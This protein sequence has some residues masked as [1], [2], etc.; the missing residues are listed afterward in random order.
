VGAVLVF[1]LTSQESFD[2]LPKWLDS[3]REHAGEGIIIILVGTKCDL[4][5][6]RKIDY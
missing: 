5:E 6:E 3:L 4:K 1:D 2:A